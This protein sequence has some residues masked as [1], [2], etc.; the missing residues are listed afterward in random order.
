MY[1]FVLISL[2]ISTALLISTSIGMCFWFALICMTFC[3]A[4]NLSTIL[5]ITWLINAFIALNAW[6]ALEVY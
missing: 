3:M 5:Q 1:L 2:L 4:T 6:A